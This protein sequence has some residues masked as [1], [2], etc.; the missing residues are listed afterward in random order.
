MG[1]LWAGPFTLLESEAGPFLERG[2][3]LI[4]NCIYYRVMKLTFRQK[5]TRS[6]GCNCIVHIQ[7]I[8]TN[9]E[10]TLRVSVVRFQTTTRQKSR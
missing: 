5:I 2:E 8:V 9:D 4:V 3:S 1:I 7:R 10:L 6:N